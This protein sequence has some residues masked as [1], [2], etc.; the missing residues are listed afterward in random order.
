MS[1]TIHQYC[2]STLEVRRPDLI[3]TLTQNNIVAQATVKKMVPKYPPIALRY[4]DST[5]SVPRLP[6]SST[7]VQTYPVFNLADKG[8]AM[9]ALE[10]IFRAEWGGLERDGRSR[11]E[12]NRVG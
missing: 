9:T 8:G 1:F 6:C 5:P 2:W 10:E 11:A 3:D 7:G 12:P 4:H